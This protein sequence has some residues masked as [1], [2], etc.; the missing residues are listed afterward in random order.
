MKILS[1]KGS[2]KCAVLEKKNE[3]DLKILFE[4]RKVFYNDLKNPIADQNNRKEILE[5][6]NTEGEQFYEYAFKDPDV[7]EFIL[8]YEENV[9]GSG[10]LIKDESNGVIDFCGGHV[11]SNY[12][13]MHLSDLLYDAREQ[14]C[15]KIGYNKAMT[16]IGEWNIASQKA[17]ERN[18]FK[19]V[20]VKCKSET[21]K[22]TYIRYEKYFL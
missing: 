11:S 18:G 6:I 12:S 3:T 7:T 19:K 1:C 9:I 15:S 16:T 14:Y 17:A 5:S 22:D 4:G 13:G 10:S 20:S 21:S 8:L 2:F